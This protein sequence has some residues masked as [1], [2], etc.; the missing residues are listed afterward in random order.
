LEAGSGLRAGKKLKEAVVPPFLPDTP[1]VRR[2]LLDYAL[3]LE[4]AD[5][6]LGKV[7]DELE[8][9]GEMEH[10]LVI[11]TSDNGMP[12]PGGKGTCG[13]YGTRVPLAL[14][15]RGRF[16]PAKREALVST[17]DVGATIFEATGLSL[18]GQG[19]G[20]SLLRLCE[21]GNEAVDRSAVFAGR[22]RQNDSD[23]RENDLGYPVRSIRTRDWLYIQNAEP[24]R[25]PG[26]GPRE[27]QG[28]GSDADQRDDP[29]AAG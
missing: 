11:A 15:W 10:T 5:E 24:G 3:E 2:D 23:S 16:A 29:V 18:P 4:W 28:P 22:V 6:Q 20:A 12:F 19:A 21:R 27:V 7:L 8:R 17:A 9:T 13:E 26:G 14:H 1:E 25:W